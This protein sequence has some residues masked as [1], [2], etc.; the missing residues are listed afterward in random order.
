MRVNCGDC[1]VRAVACS[2]CV[3]GSVL[4]PSA[5]A[6]DFE[7]GEL[8]ALSALADAGLVPRLRWSSDRLPVTVTNI[9]SVQSNHGGPQG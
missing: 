4:G 2:E 1:T 5:T 6:A 3:M 7:Q 8:A 9:T